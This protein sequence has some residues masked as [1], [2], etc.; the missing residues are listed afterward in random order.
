MKDIILYVYKK[1]GLKL[2]E[3]DAKEFIDW[4]SSNAEDITNDKEMDEK[5]REYLYNKYTGTQLNIN[6]NEEDLSSMNYLLSLLQK[7]INKQSKDK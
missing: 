5:A 6:L 2:S 3:N 1:Y 4:F 7:E